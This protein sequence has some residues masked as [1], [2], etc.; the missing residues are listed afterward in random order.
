MLL[1][2]FFWG[3]GC[4]AEGSPR[5]GKDSA[6]PWVDSVVPRLR[7]LLVLEDTAALQMEVGVLVRDFPDVR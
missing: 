1:G 6:S 7:E 2:G 3:G 4:H 5:A